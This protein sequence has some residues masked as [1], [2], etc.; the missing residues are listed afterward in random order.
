MIGDVAFGGGV[1][2]G[3]VMQGCSLVIGHDWSCSAEC[4]LIWL[5]VFD[6]ESWRWE[7]GG[8]L[9]WGLML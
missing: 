5:C 6:T 2:K 3:G 9:E 8:G 1:W 4:D 7:S